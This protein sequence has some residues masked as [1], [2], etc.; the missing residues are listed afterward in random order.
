MPPHVTPI[1]ASLEVGDIEEVP[2]H[3]V[4]WRHEGAPANAASG[5]SNAQPCM[6]VSRQPHTQA[7]SR[8]AR[9]SQSGLTAPHATARR[10]W[11][12]SAHVGLT[13]GSPLL[14]LGA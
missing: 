7:R 5:A 10:S 12:S 3:A 1:R 2:A 8:T 11:R 13:V 14:L 6:A 9:S 4:A